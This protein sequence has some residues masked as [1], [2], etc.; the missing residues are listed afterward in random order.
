M[1]GLRCAL[2]ALACLAVLRPVAAQEPESIEGMTPAHLEERGFD[3]LNGRQVAVDKAK[4]LEW[5][6]LAA[7]RG[8]PVAQLMAGRMLGSGT[9][10]PAN[11][12]RARELI[13]AAA[14]QGLAAAQGA[15]GMTYFG[16]GGFNRDLATALQWLRAAAAQEDPPSLYYLGGMYAR[17]DGV[18]RDMTSYQRLCLRSAELGFPPARIEIGLWFLHGP[19]VHDPVRGMYFLERGANSQDSLAQYDLGREYLVGRNVP[20]DLPAAVRWLESAA[21]RKNAMAGL[22]LAEL[23][24]KGLGVEHDED[25]AASLRAT[26]LAAATAPEKNAFAWEAVTG[27]DADLRNGALAV[28]IMEGLLADPKMRVAAYLDTLAAAYAETG[29]FDRAVATQLDARAA[30]PPATSPEALADFDS[31][32]ALYRAGLPFRETR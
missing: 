26:A 31:R 13:R 1:T 9:G 28:E 30:L 20:R 11:P 8:R 18:E 24:A 17:G 32:L 23:A 22:W 6:E 25:R 29:A 15:L 19:T 4:A 27:D 2:A 12:A 5:F 21:D 14:E 3:Y 16:G 10:A 7:A